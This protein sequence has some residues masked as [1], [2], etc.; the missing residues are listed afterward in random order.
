MKADKRYSHKSFINFNQRK[1]S[2]LIVVA[3]LLT[4][5]AN[6]AGICRTCEIFNAEL[7]VLD[8]MK[9]IEDQ[10]FKSVSVTADKWMP[11]K[12]VCAY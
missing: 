3:S 8:N 1:S 5:S 2:S 11:M 10:T 12:E 6:L 4:K 7:L 9:V